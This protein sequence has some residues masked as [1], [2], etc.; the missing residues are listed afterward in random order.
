MEHEIMVSP[1]EDY[2]INDI[3]SVII[4]RFILGKNVGL[5]REK[6]LSEEQ[7]LKKNYDTVYRVNRNNYLLKPPKR[8]NILKKENIEL[9]Y[10]VRLKKNLFE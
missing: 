5:N 6:E 8:Y 7:Y 2:N 9:L 1:P 3:Y 4:C 10:F